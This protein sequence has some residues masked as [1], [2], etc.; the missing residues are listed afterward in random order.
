[1]ILIRG[2]DENKQTFITNDPGV[3]NGEFFEYNEDIFYNSIRDYYTGYH[4]PIEKEKKNAIVIW[5]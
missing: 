2:Y 4:I 3:G 5:K 1:M